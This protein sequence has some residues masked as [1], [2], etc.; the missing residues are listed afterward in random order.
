MSFSSWIRKS[1]KDQGAFPKGF[2]MESPTHLS[3]AKAHGRQVREWKILIE[4]RYGFR[5]CSLCPVFS[6]FFTTHYGLRFISSTPY[7]R[8][9][10]RL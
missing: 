1:L 5:Y 10:S 2:P 4:T 6:L 7:V 8:G 9:C 3:W